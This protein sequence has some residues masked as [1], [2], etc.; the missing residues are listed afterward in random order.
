MSIQLSNKPFGMYFGSKRPLQRGR[1]LHIKIPTT[2]V[3]DATSILDLWL[4]IIAL[5][6]EE[7]A[8]VQQLCVFHLKILFTN[9]FIN[10]IFMLFSSKFVFQIETTINQ[11][12]LNSKRVPFA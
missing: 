4:K 2:V 10:A 3:F 5:R 9:P 1:G 8:G 7:L 6:I 12:I 11:C